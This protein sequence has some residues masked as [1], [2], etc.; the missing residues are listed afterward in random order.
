MLEPGHDPDLP[1]EPVGAELRGE[2]GLQ[3]LERDDP[4]VA[5]IAGP[6]DHRHPAMPDLPLDGIA[7]LESGLEAVVQIEHGVAG[8]AVP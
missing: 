7:G 2:R 1:E 3:N 8:K 6:V 4:V 5:E